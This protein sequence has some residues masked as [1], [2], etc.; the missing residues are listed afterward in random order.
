MEPGDYALALS[1]WFRDIEES[2]GIDNWEF[3]EWTFCLGYID[4]TPEGAK[5]GN[6]QATLG[7]KDNLLVIEL[8]ETICPMGDEDPLTWVRRSKELT[9]QFDASSPR[10]FLLE[11]QGLLAEQL[12]E[13]DHVDKSFCG[14]CVVAIEA[15]RAIGNFLTSI[16]D[17]DQALFQSW[18]ELLDRFDEAN[19]I[20]QYLT[21]M[22]LD[23]DFFDLPEL[24]REQVA[25][26]PLEKFLPRVLQTFNKHGIRAAVRFEEVSVTTFDM[27]SDHYGVEVFVT[28]N[29]LQSEVR[30]MH[31][32]LS[33]ATNWLPG[34]HFF[35]GHSMVKGFRTWTTE[36]ECPSASCF[37]LLLANFLRQ[38]FEF[39]RESEGVL[40]SE[41][42]MKFEESFDRLLEQCLSQKSGPTQRLALEIAASR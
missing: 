3:D 41:P 19:A 28:I 21:R 36:S 13:C 37:A 38:A 31:S 24:R 25:G 27:W 40:T 22:D 15:T 29:G 18:G 11:I 10:R 20:K 9:V 2:L 6:C 1:V 16:S 5:T 26:R 39:D 23:D 17:V 30:V 32:S 4:L 12:F 14:Y 8:D 42:A 33:M 34:Y 7:T 35:Y